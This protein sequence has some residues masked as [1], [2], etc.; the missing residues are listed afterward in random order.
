MHDECVLKISLPAK[1]E[2]YT[3]YSDKF[4]RGVLLY[5]LYIVN[6]KGTAIRQLKQRNELT[7]YFLTFAGKIIKILQN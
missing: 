2:Y 6:V 3:H 5:K 7:I 4:L 1:I